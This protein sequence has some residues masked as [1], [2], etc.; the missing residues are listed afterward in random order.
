M[1]RRQA[2]G[3]RLRPVAEDL[4]GDRGDSLHPQRADR[5][6]RANAGAAYRPAADSGRRRPAGRTGQSVERGGDRSHSPRLRRAD[7]SGPGGSGGPA[8]GDAGQPAR[9][10]ST[11][12]PSF[13]GVHFIGR[14]EFDEVTQK[15]C[16][17]FENARGGTHRASDRTI[18]EILCQRG[19]RLVFLNACETGRGG[20]ADFNSG[21]APALMAGGVPVVVA[22]QFAV[23]DVSATSF[24]RHFY[25][26]LASGFT[27]GAAAREA[28]I[29]V[30]Y[31][32]AGEAIDWAV[33][34]VYARDPSARFTRP[35]GPRPPLLPSVAPSAD[36]VRRGRPAVFRV[37]VWDVQQALPQLDGPLELLNQAQST[38]HFELVELSA[39]IGTWQ[40]RPMG[41]RQVAFLQAEEVCQK[42]EPAVAQLGLDALACITSFP[43]ADSQRPAICGYV[44]Q[45]GKPPIMLF[46]TW[47]LGVPPRGEMR[48][49]TVAN[50]LVTGL[51]W[52]KGNLPPHKRPPRNCPLF[53]NP[54]RDAGVITGRQVLDKSCRR[55]LAEK[56]SRAEINA[57][58]RLLN[59][60][61]SSQ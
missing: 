52:L 47:D 26:S 11:W 34:V 57:L 38:Y 9:D 1:G 3:V 22:N 4:S 14:G 29:A 16:L 37:G 27:V 35:P 50:L 13:D 60:F 6:T 41:D 17:L 45:D 59:V 2:V 30:N 56:L 15:G 21:V 10:G 23:L 54:K 48:D 55:K 24:A 39:P 20:K 61:R 18:R 44:P 36:L 33:P 5:R 46:S 12:Q 43:M 8:P 25:W 58:Q 31:S 53:D 28:R 51:A 32:I 19:I 42:L 40:R 7:R 49:G